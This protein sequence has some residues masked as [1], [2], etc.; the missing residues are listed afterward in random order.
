VLKV[1]L[2]PNSI[3]QYQFCHIVLCVTDHQNS[4]NL[5]IAKPISGDCWIKIWHTCL[6]VC[7]PFVDGNSKLK[8]VTVTSLVQRTL[9]N[10]H[11]EH[12]IV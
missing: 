11:D 1:P 3:N 5:R 2:N 10:S 8:T 7:V 4:V 12:S 9:M 6:C